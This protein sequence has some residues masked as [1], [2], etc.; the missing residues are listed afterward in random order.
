MVLML[1]KFSNLKQKL[2]QNLILYSSLIV[3][4]RK[5]DRSDPE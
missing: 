1:M 4:R 5:R 3:I 2:I